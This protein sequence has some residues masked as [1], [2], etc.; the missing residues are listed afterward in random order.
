MGSSRT[1][2]CELR[3]VGAFRGVW[4]VYDRELEAYSLRFWFNRATAERAL[5]KRR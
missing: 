3:R 1:L 4:R 2:F 5:Q